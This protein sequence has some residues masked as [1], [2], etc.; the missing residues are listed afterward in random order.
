MLLANLL[1]AMVDT[2]T[3]WL[4]GSGLTALQLAFMRYATH[5]AVTA[6]ETGARVKTPL[7]G[8]LLGLTVLRSFC[9]VSATVANFFAIGHLSLAVSSAILYVF[10]VIV[11][12]FSWVLLDERITPAHWLGVAAGL[13][14][15]LVIVEPFGEGIN[16]YALL[17]LYPAT[18]MALYSVLTRMLSGQVRPSHLQF[19]TGLMGTA[20]LLPFA[21]T[22]WVWPQ[23]PL[24]WVL[25]CAIGIFAWVGHECLTRA[26][27]YASASTLAPFGYSFIVYLSIAG[28]LVF[29]DVPTRSTLIG[30]VLVFA[31]GLIIWRQTQRAG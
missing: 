23:A 3:K 12:L 6:V 25:M 9:L 16:W 31:G 14:G 28:W 30:A 27:A 2:S 13:L 7:R 29:G 11:F 17:M 8:R 20:A 1:F 21:L 19:T 10:P 5:F 4:L 24:E 26:H 22:S 18:G 15:V